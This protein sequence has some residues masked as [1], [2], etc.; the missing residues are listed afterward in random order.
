MRILHLDFETRSTVDLKEVGPVEYARHASTEVIAAAWSMQDGDDYAPVRSWYLGMSRKSKTNPYQ[1]SYLNF[2]L[3]AAHNSGFERAIWNELLV[4]RFGF[5]Y[6][7]I[8][9]FRCSSAR[10]AMLGLPASLEGVAD[11]LRLPVK[12]DVEGRALMLSM[13]SPQTVIKSPNLFGEIGPVY[14]EDRPSL[15]RLA[16]YC[17][18]DVEVEIAVDKVNGPMTPAELKIWLIDQ[19]INQRG[20][21][22][23]RPLCRRAL[24]IVTATLKKRGAQ[25]GEL[26]GGD[27]TKATQG[28][29]LI[30]WINW[31]GVPCDSL[32]ADIVAGLLDGDLPSDVREVLEIRRDSAKS[33][34]AKFARMLSR[35]ASD[36]RMRDNLRYHGAFTGRW[37]GQGAQI[38]N[39]PRGSIEFM[40]L[41]AECFANESIALIEMM[42]GDVVDAAKSLL[43][44]CLIA[45][46]DS[47]LLV[48]D[49]AQIEARVLPWLSGETWKLNAF[50]ELDAGRGFDIYVLAYAVTF[51][52]DP[53]T[54][55]KAQRQ[56]GKVIELALGYGGGP[57]AFVS[58]AKIYRVEIADYLG[59]LRAKFP[60]VATKAR[61]AYNK[62]GR[63]SDIPRETWIAAEIVKT[64]WR[65]KHPKTVAFWYALNDAAIECV[66]TGRRTAAGRIRFQLVGQFLKMILP[67]N[68]PISYFRPSVGEGRF[69]P[70]LVYWQTKDG[71]LMRITTYGGKLCENA[72]QAVAR[73]PMTDGMKRLRAAKFAMV[74]TVHDEV[75]AEEKSVIAQARL[76]E[77]K[78]LLEINA[79]WSKGLPLVV[80]GFVTNRYKK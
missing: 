2:D 77:G 56:L 24:A 40:E 46:D 13:T 11:A 17:A 78:K 54:V 55:T 61:E 45:D 29:R 44:G 27:A 36:G 65:A 48:W 5:K 80:D 31:R 35:S 26:T 72:T 30:K 47:K 70:E 75:I 52:V 76:D 49:Y 59:E 9:R 15:R 16:E 42:F 63:Q 51:G 43:R 4:P 22:I 71:R 67:S 28:A 37:A 62:R 33:S 20:I 53:A 8:K 58:F 3:I 60:D 38:Q 14:K 50:R 19:E 57:G 39:Y 74:G 1:L 10:A 79:P 21:R 66:R 25:L 12:K 64:N 32:G 7:P 41:L 6:V 69:G 68:R 18:T 23:D 73:D 34:T